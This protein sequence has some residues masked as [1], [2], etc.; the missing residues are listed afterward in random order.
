MSS[1]NQ[2]VLRYAGTFHFPDRKVLESALAVARARVD[3]EQELAALGGG[4]LRCFVM[5]DV[6]LTINIAL[7]ALPEH[8]A[9]AEEI[10]ELLSREALDGTLTARVDNG[11]AERYVIAPRTLHRAATTRGVVAQS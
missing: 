4:W 2:T 7:P 11:P 8:R 1:P 9:A 10:F 6:T 3:Q 5:S